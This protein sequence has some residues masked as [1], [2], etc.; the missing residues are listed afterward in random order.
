MG[1]LVGA[2]AVFDLELFQRLARVNDTCAADWFVKIA[3]RPFL[4]SSPCLVYQSDLSVQIWY[5]GNYQ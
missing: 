4:I 2:P 3:L 1:L 5:C